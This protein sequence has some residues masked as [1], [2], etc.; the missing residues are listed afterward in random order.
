[1]TGDVEFVGDGRAGL[2]Q[3]PAQRLNGLGAQAGNLFFEFPDAR[4][5]LRAR[6]EARPAFG[7]IPGFVGLSGVERLRAL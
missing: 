4:R 5:G 7:P 1:M 6:R 2:G 3:A